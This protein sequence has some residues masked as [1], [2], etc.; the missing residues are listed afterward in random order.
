MRGLPLNFDLPICQGTIFQQMNIAE[1]CIDFVCK[2]Y[3]VPVEDVMSYRRLMRIVWPRYVAMLMC[4]K[5]GRMSLNEIGVAM[6]RDHSCVFYGLKKLEA[7]IETDK[8]IAKDVALI[9][10]ALMKTF[11]FRPS[12]TN[13][14][15]S[16]KIE[17]IE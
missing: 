15:T 9:E 14:Y 8:Q 11:D 17:G 3:G 7:A 4:R 13:G 2:A 1:Q 16:P 6:N 12:N 10:S 5:L